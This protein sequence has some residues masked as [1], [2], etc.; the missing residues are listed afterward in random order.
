MELSP[1]RISYLLSKIG[2]GRE[3]PTLGSLPFGAYGAYRAYV[4]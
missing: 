2:R 3:V 1:R 4:Q